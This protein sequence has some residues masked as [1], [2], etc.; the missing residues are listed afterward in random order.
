MFVK[1]SLY[2]KMINKRFS[3]VKNKY[4]M[5]KLNIFLK[6]QKVRFLLKRNKTKTLSK[7]RSESTPG[8]VLFIL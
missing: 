3:L 4:A 8:K 2:R 6:E 7:N 1:A 5:M